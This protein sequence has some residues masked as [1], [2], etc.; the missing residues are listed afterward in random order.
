LLPALSTELDVIR[1]ELKTQ[2]NDFGTYRQI[3]FAGL[4]TFGM[5][6]RRAVEVLRGMQ[7]LLEAAFFTGV[8]LW[9]W[10]RHVVWNSR[11][12]AC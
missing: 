3:G 10:G 6:R 9:V 11:G 4:C 2:M 8:G 5:P 12:H 1:Y 7:L